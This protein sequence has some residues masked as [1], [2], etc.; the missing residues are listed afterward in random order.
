MTSVNKI[1]SDLINDIET[2]AAGIVNEIKSS[3]T[4]SAPAE[5]VPTAPEAPTEGTDEFDPFDDDELAFI[6]VGDGISPAWEAVEALREAEIATD[7]GRTE[8]AASYIAIADRY[9]ALADIFKETEVTFS[10]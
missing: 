1:V 10:L 7:E 5:E 8:Q 9:I 3:S 4:T 2:I 6:L